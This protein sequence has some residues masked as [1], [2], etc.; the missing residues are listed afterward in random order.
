MGSFPIIDFSAR[1]Y[2]P[3]ARIWKAYDQGSCPL[4]EAWHHGINIKIP[5]HHYT[6]AGKLSISEFEMRSLLEL[7]QMYYEMDIHDD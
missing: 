3:W 4:Q 1:G 7:H 5:E 2:D 6:E